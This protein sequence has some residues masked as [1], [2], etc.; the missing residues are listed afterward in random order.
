MQKLLLYANMYSPPSRVVSLT[1]ECL[2][3]KYKLVEIFPLNGDTMTPEF[4]EVRTIDGAKTMQQ[5]N[6]EDHRWRY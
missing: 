4:L 3:L 5:S 2:N 1:L 6:K